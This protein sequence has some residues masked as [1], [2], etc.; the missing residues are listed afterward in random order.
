M[1]YENDHFS[2]K[3][4]KGNGNGDGWDWWFPYPAPAKTGALLWR[5]GVA[6][7][8]QWIPT[9]IKLG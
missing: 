6:F 4:K 3:K 5:E 9:V 1:C 7:V 8:L 2:R